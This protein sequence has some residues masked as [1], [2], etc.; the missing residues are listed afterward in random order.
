MLTLH[1][2]N[3]LVPQQPHGA[4]QLQTGLVRFDD[5]IDVTALGG[6]IRDRQVEVVA[7]TSVLEGEVITR[8]IQAGVIGY[9]PFDDDMRTGIVQID[10]DHLL[11]GDRHD[12]QDNEDE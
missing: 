10:I 1:P 12:D 4:A 6:D 11:T 5:R 8:A 2:R 7:L 9:L 3:L